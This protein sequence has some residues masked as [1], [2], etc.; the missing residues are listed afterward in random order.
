MIDLTKLVDA[1]RMYKHA[2]LLAFSA[3]MRSQGLKDDETLVVPLVDLS[4]E[5]DLRLLCYGVRYQTDGKEVILAVAAQPFNPSDLNSVP[6]LDEL[7]I[8]L[9]EIPGL[10]EKTR[11]RVVNKTSDG[12]LSETSQ[13]VQRIPK[14]YFSKIAAEALVEILETCLPEGV[15]KPYDKVRYVLLQ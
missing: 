2:D 6:S 1:D 11:L 13:T 4:E 3:G 8:T 5:M 10:R 7:N 15:P 9:W 12:S 14:P